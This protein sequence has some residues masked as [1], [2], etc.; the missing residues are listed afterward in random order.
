VIS[1]Y[2]RTAPFIC[3]PED[4]ANSILFLASDESR[5]INGAAICLDNTA[6]IHPPY[7]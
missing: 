4:V 3:Q 2:Q 5:H 6:T 7:L 1:G